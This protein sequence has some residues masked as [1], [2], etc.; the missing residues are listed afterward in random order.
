MSTE[1]P[2]ATVL[3]V[4]DEEDLRDAMCRM[5]QRRG[6]ATIPAADPNQAVAVCRDHE[7][8]IDVLLTDL[9]MPGASGGELAKL[10]TSIRPELRVLYV[11]GLTREV[12]VDR[13]LVGDKAALVQKPFTSDGLTQAVRTVLRAED[14]TF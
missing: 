13:G 10:A 4:D 7:G 2:G 11:T 8:T 1:A 6:F 5:L 12:A 3:V 9:G 14:I